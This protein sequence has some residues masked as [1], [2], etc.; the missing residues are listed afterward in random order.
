MGRAHLSVTQPTGERELLGCS[1]NSAK[2]PFLFISAAIVLTL[3]SSWEPSLK[4]RSVVSLLGL[5]S[6]ST[7]VA[8]ASD[9]RW[10]IAQNSSYTRIHFPM[11][12]LF[13]SFIYV[14]VYGCLACMYVCLPRTDNTCESQ[15]GHPVPLG[16]GLATIDSHNVGSGDRGKLIWKSS[17]CS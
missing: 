14:C 17:Q 11:H 7:Y 1:F 10:F 15:R 16:L 13:F 8:Q 6:I 2:S 12:C 3:I 4:V 9:K 5:N